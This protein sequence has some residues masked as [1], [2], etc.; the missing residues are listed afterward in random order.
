MEVTLKPGDVLYFPR[1]YIHQ[2]KTEKKHS[3]H[4]TISVYQKT[5]RCDL[6]EKVE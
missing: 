3:L 5:S 1:G 4:L 6:L 2:A